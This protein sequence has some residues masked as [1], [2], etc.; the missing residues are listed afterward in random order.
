MNRP[1]RLGVFALLLWL[2]WL[3]AA[4]ASEGSRVWSAVRIADPITPV[5]AD[6]VAAELIRANQ[7]GHGAFLVELDTPGGLDGAMRTI[8]QAFLTSD[9]PVVV[10]VYPS[11]GRA[12]SAGALI[13]L[14]ADFAAMAPG[15]HIGAAHPLPIGS[16]GDQAPKE[17]LSKIVE[18]AAAYA[19]SIAQ[20][21]GR[22]AEQAERMVRDSLSLAAEEAVALQVVDL[23]AEDRAALLR[24]LD[25]RRY[26]R[27]DASRILATADLE[28]RPVEMNWR[29]KVLKTISHPNVAY[30][31]LMLGM[32]GIFFEIAQPGTIF[33]GAIGAMALLLALFAFQSLPVNTAGLLLILLALVLFVLEISVESYGLLSIGGVISMAM[34]SMMLTAGLE[35]F[36][37]ISPLLIAATVAVVSGLLL[38]VLYAVVRAQRG[39]FQSGAE[40]MAGER[41]KAV[42]AIGADGRVFVHGE[43]WQAYSREP[44]A[45]GESIE[46]V[47]MGENLRLEVRRAAAPDSEP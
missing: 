27:G 42:T 16:Q 33:P 39:T 24:A 46:V 3:P 4:V 1:V 32:L 41:G 30:L 45:A 11:G 22:N 35:P 31:L 29:Q 15:T 47:Q 6:F 19:R 40:G 26:R 5:L 44:I 9:I 38:L 37:R 13:T 18:D 7:A 8:I 25:G 10:Y 21:R 28:I 23:V 34:G 12:A 17:L 36:W 20:R 14:A 43:Y 2:L